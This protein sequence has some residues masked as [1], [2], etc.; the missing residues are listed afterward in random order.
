MFVRVSMLAVMA[1]CLVPVS[2]AQGQG[3][4]RGAQQRAAVGQGG[5]VGTTAATTQ[6]AQQRKG[7]NKA[8]QSQQA[9]SNVGG[10]RVDGPVRATVSG[11]PASSSVGTAGMTAGT[12]VRGGAAVGP[13]TRPPGW[14]RGEKAGWGGQG[15]PPG[16]AKKN[17]MATGAS[18]GAARGNQRP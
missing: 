15:M 9:G 4:G 1:I 16:L 10:A 13:T 11:G 14:D 7:A 12:A 2:P 18:R 8:A 17:G 6:P 5:T 3:R